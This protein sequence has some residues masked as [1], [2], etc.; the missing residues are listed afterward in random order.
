MVIKLIRIVKSSNS[1]KKWTAIFMVDDKEKKV[2]FGASGYRDYTLINN[3]DS[4]FYLPKLV[5]RN[6]VKASYI[7][8]HEKNENWNNPLTA[9][10]LSRFI[11]WNKK[12]LNASIRD[13][14]RR[15]KV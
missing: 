3:K 2:D 14:K 6:V 5:D 11:L 10:A 7:R 9:G 12:S 4:K 1:A 15:F 13:F 8:R